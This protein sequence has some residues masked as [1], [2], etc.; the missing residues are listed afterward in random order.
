MARTPTFLFAASVPLAAF[1]FPGAARPCGYDFSPVTALV[2]SS[3]AP[4]Q[5]P[6]AILVIERGGRV[7]YQQAFGSY[8]MTTTLPTASS[9][10]WISAAVVMSVVDS[11]QLSLDSTT[12]QVLGWAGQK[13]TIT[14]RQLF[15]HTSGFRDA[16]C[17]SQSTVTLAECVDQIYQFETLAF[18]PG[19]GFFYGGAG[20][21][22]AGRM[23][24]VATGQS[25]SSL[26]NARVRAPL[27]MTAT[28]YTPIGTPNPRVAGGAQTRALEYIGMLRM[29]LNGGTLNGMRVLS[30]ASVLAML[31][32]QTGGAPPVSTPPTINAY[33]GYGVGNWLWRVNPLGFAVDFSSPGAFGA[34]PWIDTERDTAC[35]FLVADSLQNVDGLVDTLQPLIRGVIDAGTLTGDTDFDGDVDFDDLN[36]VLGQFGQTGGGLSGDLTRDGA[37]GF[38]D[39]N[40]VLSGYGSFCR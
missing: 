28:A 21:Q 25:W 23:C 27:G 7:L 32:D 37:V 10:K 18:P 36:T 15:S 16:P 6:G 12:A 38:P 26:F 22:V 39:L 5:L 35:I 29:Y 14:L 13:G 34:S 3:L 9:V 20:M 33:Q 40:R 17:L 1:S 11:G 30:E 24:E 2:Q 4:L 8:T 19:T 31:R